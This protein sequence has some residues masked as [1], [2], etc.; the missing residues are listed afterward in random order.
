MTE[1]GFRMVGQAVLHTNGYKRLA[2][3]CKSWDMC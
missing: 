3:Y 1:I 2:M